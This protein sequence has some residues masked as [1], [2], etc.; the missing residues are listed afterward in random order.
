MT[1]RRVVSLAVLMPLLAALVVVFGARPSFACSCA[2]IKGE[3]VPY[4]I[5][6]AVFTGKVL[7]RREPGH[8]F[9][10]GD[11][12]I[13]VF[14]VQ[15]VYKGRVHAVQAVRTAVSGASCGLE[16]PDRGRFLV[17]AERSG[18]GVLT[19][20]LC[21]GT[22]PVGQAPVTFAATGPPLAGR[23]VPPDDSGP[24]SWQLGAAALLVVGAGA[25]VGT[26]LV[27]RRRA[28]RTARLV[29]SRPAGG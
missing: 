4:R 28:F 25:A 8:G 9:S 3:S 26:V 15:T 22:R 12:A 7:E 14:S 27:R 29:D 2:L 11:P 20:N 10:S 23:S 16:I 13:Y 1:L 6:D 21:G 17:F 19:A 18:D 24:S 5:A